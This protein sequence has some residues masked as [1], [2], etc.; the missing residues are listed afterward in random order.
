MH[1]IC[2]PILILVHRLHVDL[3]IDLY[4]HYHVVKKGSWAMI[5]GFLGLFCHYEILNQDTQPQLFITFILVSQNKRQT[6]L[7]NS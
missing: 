2:Q 4:T 6:L 1:D 5:S 3:Y 7:D